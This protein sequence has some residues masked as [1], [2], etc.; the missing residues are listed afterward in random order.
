MG[1]LT[2]RVDSLAYGGKAVGRHE[3]IVYFI[4]DGVPGDLVEIQVTKSEKRYKEAEIIQIIEESP[5]RCVQPC[6][7]AHECG[8]CQWQHVKYDYQLTSKVTELASALNKAGLSISDKTIKEPTPSPKVFEYRRTARFKIEKESVSGK[9]KKGFYSEKS[10]NIVEID[11]CMLLNPKINEAFKTVDVSTDGIKGFDL[12]L[13]DEGSVKPF[14]RFSERDQGADFFQVNTEVNNLMKSYIKD[15]CENLPKGFKI[16][17]LYCGDG[18]LSLD[19]AKAASSIIGW[20]Y[21]K[22]A[23]DRGNAKAEK[24][25]QLCKINFRTTDINRNWKRIAPIAAKADLLL[26]DPPRKGLKKQ[27]EKIAKLGAPYIIYVSC[28][29]PALARDL[30]TFTAAGYSIEELKPFD[31]FPQT[32]HLETVTILKK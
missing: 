23:I 19:F 4:K 3:G 24:L 25:N 20:D 11:N 13:D 29:P 26:L 10:N 1:K 21:S 7:Y 31:M 16:A 15:K 9:I 27:A 5:E 17:D 32:Y 12:F 6:K 18:N 8:G 22:T 2:I 30:K 28:A 14:Y